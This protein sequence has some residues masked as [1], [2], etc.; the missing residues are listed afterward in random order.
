[1]VLGPPDSGKTSWFS[2]F[3]G[4]NFTNVNRNY[5]NGHK[6]ENKTPMWFLVSNKLKLL[7]VEISTVETH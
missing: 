5:F 6:V 7:S 1:M 4:N 3:Q 2:P